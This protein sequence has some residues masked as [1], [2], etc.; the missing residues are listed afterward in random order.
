MSRG[1]IK[2]C[3][4]ALIAVMSYC[5]SPTFA[6]SEAESFAV[7]LSNPGEPAVFELSG[8][9]QVTVIGEDRDDMEFSVIPMQ[10]EG[11]QARGLTRIGNSPGF[12]VEELNNVVKFRP[13]WGD[14]DYHVIARVPTETS[15]NLSTRNSDVM[16][17]SGVSG[18]HELS[19]VNADI[20]GE[21][22]SGSV[23]AETPNGDLTLSFTSVTPDTP[24][25]FSSFNGDV[26]LT[27]PPSYR[28]NA[29]IDSGRGAT[30]TDFDF[31]LEESP[32]IVD[33][34]Q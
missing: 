21:N 8:N 14:G 5:A 9:L 4:L 6:A 17:I 16:S 34:Q 28:A 20:Y 29:R 10:E 12:V 24:M 3:G 1:V 7:E 13:N 23:S 32:P 26:D 22:I 27:L 2:Q 25:A 11:Q 33:N 31:E 15:L 19:N 18:E 30:Y